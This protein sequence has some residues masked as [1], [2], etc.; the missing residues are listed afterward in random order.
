MEVKKESMTLDRKV[1]SVPAKSKPESTTISFSLTR[2]EDGFVIQEIEEE[3]NSKEPEIEVKTPETNLKAN[4]VKKGNKIAEIHKKQA[5]TT[6]TPTKIN[7][8]NTLNKS[9]V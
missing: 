4:N 9:K 7:K 5:G 8:S 3:K 6:R 2:P 1:A